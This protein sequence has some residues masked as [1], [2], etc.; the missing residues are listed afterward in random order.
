MGAL[1]SYFNLIKIKKKDYK[2]FGACFL[3]A[4]LFWLFSTL[5][6]EYTIVIELP[7]TYTGL[8]K[9]KLISNK[10]PRLILVNIKGPGKDVLWHKFTSSFSNLELKVEELMSYRKVKTRAYIEKNVL[11]RIVDENVKSSVQ[12][13]NIYPDI[14]EFYFE[15]K[16]IKKVPIEADI[17]YASF[18]SSYNSKVTLTPDSVTI[19]GPHSIIRKID[20][21]KTTILD[22]E[23][24]K[25][26]QFKSTISLL[27]PDDHKLSIDADQVELSIDVDQLIQINKVIP[28]EVLNAPIGLKL[29]Q[30]EVEI[31]F[32][33]PNSRINQMEEG[34]IKVGI[35]FNDINLEVD[36]SA[37]LRINQFP[38]YIKQ[39]KLSEPSVKFIIQ[40]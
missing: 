2:V 27:K 11:F 25:E 16:L 29:F 32:Y 12:I 18:I 8:P 35:D 40:E 23:G 24:I 10:L 5:S 19:S 34:N 36:N 20:Y 33:I 30:N 13:V 4:F 38:I 9:K 21:W 28:I 15:P 26:N 17:E 6:K 37:P 1:K 7:V 14:L 3:F 31:S 22:L 39:V